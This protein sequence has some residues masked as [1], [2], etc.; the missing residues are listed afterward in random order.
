MS[1][2]VPN[3]WRPRLRRYNA[4]GL[5]GAVLVGLSF[6]KSVALGLGVPLIPVHHIRGHIAANYLA[7]PELEPPFLALAISGGS[8]SSPTCWA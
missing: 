1:C 5:I 3:F 7:F 6:A 4:P 2:S 8:S